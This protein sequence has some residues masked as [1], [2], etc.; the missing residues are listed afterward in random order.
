M[1]YKTFCHVL[2]FTL[3]ELQMPSGQTI[4]EWRKF[5]NVYQHPK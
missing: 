2:K 3:H 1:K 4:F 5:S